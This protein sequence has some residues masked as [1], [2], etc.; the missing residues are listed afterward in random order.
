MEIPVL[1]MYKAR[2]ISILSQCPAQLLFIF[3]FVIFFTILFIILFDFIRSYA[4]NQES[5]KY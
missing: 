4:P 2:Q 1:I 3:L 5:S